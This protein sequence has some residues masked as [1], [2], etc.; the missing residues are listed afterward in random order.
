MYLLNA[1][2]KQLEEFVDPVPPYAIL[3]HTWDKD[4]LLFQDVMRGG[5]QKRGWVKV[6]L[7]CRQAVKD[8]HNYVWIDTC[9]CANCSTARLEAHAASQ[10]RQEQ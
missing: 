2:T 7:A 4:E 10:H 8:G 6:D 3:S 1:R 5:S 9:W